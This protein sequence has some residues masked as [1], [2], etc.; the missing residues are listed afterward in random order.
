M[1][2]QALRAAGLTPR[3][4]AAWAGTDRIPAL[5]VDE[6]AARPHT[7]AAHALALFVAGKDVDAD[8]RLPVDALLERGLVEESHGKLHAEVAI[9]PVGPSLIVCDRHD[10]PPTSERVCWPDDSSYHLALSIPKGRVSSWLDLGCGSAFAP[11]AH[12]ELASEILGIELNPIA[13]DMARLGAELSGVS[14][15]A[16]EH[17]D[18]AIDVPPAQLVTCNAPMPRAT[19][20]SDVEMW[21]TTDD[22]LFER[23]WR[24]VPERLVETGLAVIHAAVSAMPLERLTGER[25]LVIYTPPD[26]A[27]AF[28]VLWWRPDAEDRLAVSHRVLTA[29]HPHVTAADRSLTPT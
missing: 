21:R 18:L 24:I 23:L 29:E 10:A 12:P 3:A 14:H 26:V 4:L 28:G 11:L 16:I 2:G 7:P 8:Q 1:I 15:I 27:P 5:R 9:L 25:R 22:D 17:A 6:L 19:R 13:A 20:D